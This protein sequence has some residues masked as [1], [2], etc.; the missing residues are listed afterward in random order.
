MSTL[1]KVL[2]EVST[3][4]GD[5][6]TLLEYWASTRIPDGLFLQ[7]TSEQGCAVWL[8]PMNA[9]AKNLTKTTEDQLICRHED[10]T[11]MP[12]D[13]LLGTLT[14]LKPPAESFGTVGI[15]MNPATEIVFLGSWD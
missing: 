3:A 8:S 12:N 14:D 6:E 4:Y 5:E 7:M 11:L 10:G 1:L 15:F 9:R 13:W 2:T